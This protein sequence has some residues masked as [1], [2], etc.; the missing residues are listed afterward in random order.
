MRHLSQWKVPGSPR[1]TFR[2]TFGRTQGRWLFEGLLAA[3]LGLGALAVLVLLFWVISPYPDNGATGALRIA[4]D[5]WLLA[6]GCELVRGE[7]LHQGSAPVGLSPLLLTALPG[8]L[9]YRAVRVTLLP[10]PE[11]AHWAA[12]P[13]DAF[14]AAL[15]IC[16][17][18]LLAGSAATLFAARATLSPDL[19]DTAIQLPLFAL[20]V[21]V[22]TAWAISGVPPDPLLRHAPGARWSALFTARRLHA[23]GRAALGGAAACCGIGAL[24]A[25]GGLLL[26]AQAAQSTMVT[27]SGDWSG[28]LAVL[29]LACALAPNAAVW[30][31]AYGLGPGFTLGG[32]S[33]LTPL[34]VTGEPS[35]PPFPLLDGLPASAP[36]GPLLW[37]TAA[38]PLAGLL[39]IATLVARAA[40]PV[41][42]ERASASGWLGTS[43][44]AL[45]A[46]AGTGVALG[47]LGAMA[48][49]PLG[50]GELARF[51]PDGWLTGLAAA[52][53]AAVAL[54]LALGLRLWRLHQPRL[55]L[56]S[57]TIGA[58]ATLRAVTAQ[59]PR[60]RRR[61]CR[62]RAKDPA[63]D[64]HVTDARHSRWAAL[65][66]TSGE[67]VPELG[68]P[69]PPGLPDI[70]HEAGARAQD[71]SS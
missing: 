41:P 53:W 20:L 70:P 8:W 26:H 23:A 68:P 10:E 21:T 42:G 27:L 35:P 1:P 4:A 57:L 67:L 63:R 64:W 43:L 7:T 30:G 36:E 5:L 2:P 28:R 60:P 65:R 51:G 56:A 9:L 25:A 62:A 16:A 34:A 17:G 38:V 59:A 37:I 15:W 18:Y 48:G 40:V 61:R 69:G 32:G 47:L 39:V 14:R 54:P 24:L 58:L 71:R 3:G 29:L 11:Q 45:L 46:A 31:A 49:G 13:G 52:G 44:T 19:L 6:H 22:A 12:D 33:L 50:T 66:E 55:L